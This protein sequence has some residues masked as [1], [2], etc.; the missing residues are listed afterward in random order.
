MFECPVLHSP[1]CRNG[2]KASAI[3]S[4]PYKFITSTN[5]KRELYDLSADPN[6]TR[7]LYAAMPDRSKQL[8]SDLNDWKK[9]A[10]SKTLQKRN[11][12]PEMMRRLKSLGYA[13]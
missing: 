6:E 4:W 10:P 9:T 2:C 3:Y 13:Q 11:L 8:N 12:D 7:D 1:D 5:G